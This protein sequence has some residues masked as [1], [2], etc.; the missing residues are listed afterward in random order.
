MKAWAAYQTGD[1]AA[2]CGLCQDILGKHQQNEP[3]YFEAVE[4]LAAMQVRCGRLTEALASYDTALSIRPHLPDALNNRANVLTALRRFD[5]A[6]ADFDRALAARPD[7]VEALSN[8]GNLLMRMKRPDEALASYDKALAIRPRYPMVLNNRGNALC[9]LR[10]FDEAVSS[11]DQAL[12]IKPNFVAAL[13]NRALVLAALRRF[14]EAFASC[15]QSLAL[16][17]GNA[18]ALAAERVIQREFAAFQEA[19][20]TR[21]NSRPTRHDR[22]D[23]LERQRGVQQQELSLASRPDVAGASTQRSVIQT[24]PRRLPETLKSFRKM[25]ELPP[26]FVEAYRNEVELH[27]LAGDFRGAWREY[28]QQA[29]SAASAVMPSKFSKPQWDGLERLFDQTILLHGD[30]AYGDTI[31][32][33]RYVPLLARRGAHVVIKVESPLRQLIA[34]VADVVQVAPDENVALSF[35]FHCPFAGSAAR[36]RNNARD[37]SRDGPLFATRHKRPQQNGTPG[38]APKGAG[39]SASSGRAMRRRKRSSGSIELATFLKL[40]DDLDATFVCA[41]RD[42]SGSDAAH[43]ASAAG[44]F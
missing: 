18:A 22:A 7:F 44:K 25:S 41:Q 11:L 12:A 6:L 8:R 32:F 27:L 4:L 13:S 33:C 10:R 31:Q 28:D 26:E 35:D 39:G 40:L 37:Y 29:K 36:I 9:A 38:L 43:I 3:I 19:G 17:P 15:K 30:K 16:Q 34:G 21:D 2:A 42:I 1:V 23:T 14:D 24:G 20:A 5:E